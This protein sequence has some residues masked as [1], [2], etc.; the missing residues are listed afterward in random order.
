MPQIQGGARTRIPIS[1]SLRL[2]A[3][4]GTLAASCWVNRLTTL[5]IGAGGCFF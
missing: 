1:E 2:R 5:E 4:S 3:C